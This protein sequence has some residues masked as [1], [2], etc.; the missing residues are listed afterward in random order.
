MESAPIIE[1]ALM[2][3]AA[4]L[5]LRFEDNDSAEQA[6]DYLAQVGQARYPGRAWTRSFTVDGTTALAVITA[7]E[8]NVLRAGN[9]VIKSTQQVIGPEACSRLVE[10][11]TTAVLEPFP[12]SRVDDLI[13]SGIFTWLLTHGSPLDEQEE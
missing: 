7:D 1:R 9:Q 6:K 10:C 5:T 11:H 13:Q 12:A 2:L 4:R 8:R 3:A